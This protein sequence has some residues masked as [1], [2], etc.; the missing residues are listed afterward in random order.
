VAIF[1]PGFPF[2]AQGLGC[3]LFS[4]AGGL[5]PASVIGGAPLY[6]PTP[7]LVA[8][9]NGLIT[10]GSQ[11]GQVIGPPLVAFAVSAGGGWHS[12]PWVLGGAAFLGAALSLPV[13]ALERRRAG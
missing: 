9:T 4:S 12:A 2:W 5:L 6:A 11:L 13:A 3:L 10:Q 1:I 7:K 8:T